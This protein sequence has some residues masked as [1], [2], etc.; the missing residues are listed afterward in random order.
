MDGS[1]QRPELLGGE[2]GVAYDPTHGESVDWIMARDRD[3]SGTVSHYDVLA[4]ASDS[5]AGL[6]RALTAAGWLT[7]GIRGNVRLRLRFLELLNRR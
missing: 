4:L 2:A 5:K 7:P 6:S 1:Q 3:N